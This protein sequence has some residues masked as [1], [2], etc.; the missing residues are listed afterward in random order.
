MLASAPRISR[1]V[2]T[3][4]DGEKLNVHSLE[5]KFRKQLK[6][7]GIKNANLH[8]WRH[9]FASYLMMRSGNIRAVQK[10]LGHKSI[11]TTEIYA[12]LSE[13]HL[14]HVVSMLPSPKP[15]TVLVTPVVLPGKGIVQV[16]D[17][18]VVGDTGFEP[19]TSTV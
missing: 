3:K 7:L 1:W 8:T 12:H 14:H 16:V 2:F 18:K 17:N 9:T 6:R 5:T 4:Q 15:V 10:L 13:R 11:R 19:V